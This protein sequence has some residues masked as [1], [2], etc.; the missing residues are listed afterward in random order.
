[1]NRSNKD[2]GREHTRSRSG[3]AAAQKLFPGP[4][5]VHLIVQYLHLDLVSTKLVFKILR[6]IKFRSF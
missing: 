1:M 6:Y 2:I 3:A 4:V 5:H